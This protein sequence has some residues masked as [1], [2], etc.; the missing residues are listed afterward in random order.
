L[1]L[2]ASEAFKK[3]IEEKNVVIKKLMREKG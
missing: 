3:L 2:G 1:T